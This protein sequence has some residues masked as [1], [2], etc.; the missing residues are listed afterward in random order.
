MIVVFAQ[1]VTVAIH[2][3]VIRIVPVSVSVRQQLMIVM[4]VQVVVLVI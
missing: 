2:Q 3:T 4:Y 1:R